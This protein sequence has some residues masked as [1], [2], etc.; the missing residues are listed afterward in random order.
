MLALAQ[1]S[2]YQTNV[3]GLKQTIDKLLLS[4]HFIVIFCSCGYCRAVSSFLLWSSKTNNLFSKISTGQYLNVYVR[5]KQI[6]VKAY[7]KNSTSYSKSWIWSSITH[8]STKSRTLSFSKWLNK[9]KKPRAVSLELSISLLLIFLQAFMENFI[10]T[11]VILLPVLV[12]K[13]FMAD[14]V[15]KFDIPLTLSYWSIATG[16]CPIPSE[17]IYTLLPMYFVVVCVVVFSL[18]IYPSLLFLVVLHKLPGDCLYRRLAI[19]QLPPVTAQFPQKGF[20]PYSLR[21]SLLIGLL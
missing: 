19:A 2:I 16:H 13:V 10:F 20:L 11:R 17:V 5:V 18:F 9:V 12:I 1:V 7:L 21:I 14:S 15:W 3:I 4:T 8:I 6:I